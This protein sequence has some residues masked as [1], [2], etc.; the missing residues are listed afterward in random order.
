MRLRPEEATIRWTSNAS[1]VGLAQSGSGFDQCVEHDLKVESRPADGLEHVGSSSLL[2]QG[3]AQLVKQTRVLGGDDSLIGK[4]LNQLNLFVGERAHFRA[5]DRNHPDQLV[6]LEHW[7]SKK[8]A[9]ANH[10]DHGNRK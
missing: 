10:L 7:H 9:N 8:R 1:E 6:L 2:V 4:I 3:L 5:V